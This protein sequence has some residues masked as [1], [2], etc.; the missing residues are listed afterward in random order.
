MSEANAR[1]AALA[2]IAG[3]A[4][5]VGAIVVAA[6]LEAD[7]LDGR[8][9]GPGLR[10]GYSHVYSFVS[11]LAAVGSDGRVVMV[12]GFIGFGVCTVVLAGAMRRLWP[13]ATLLTAVVALSGVGLIGAGS[14]TCDAGCPTEG[15]LSLAQEVHNITSVVT[16]PAW[17][18]CAA[19]AAWQLRD[20]LYGRLSLVLAVVEVGSGLVLGTWRD[21]EADD[22]VGLLQRVNLAAVCAWFVLT[23]L[24]VRRRPAP[25]R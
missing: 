6:L 22:P 1:Q 10:D 24:E 20:R 4:L 11:E 3:P 17:M 23:A 12:V 15:D 5:W 16:F 25:G 8:P 14:F 19:I 21:R 18:A 13:T 9:A 7:R 2:G